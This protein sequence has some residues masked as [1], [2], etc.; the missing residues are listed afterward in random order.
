MPRKP[1]PPSGRLH[2]RIAPDL[3]ARVEAAAAACRPRQDVSTYTRQALEER[4]DRAGAELSAWREGRAAGLREARAA[5]ERL[6]E[7]SDQ[8]EP[9][10]AS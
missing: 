2:L 3:L 1:K 8:P 6:P 9:D 5:L 7:P 4:M 10:P